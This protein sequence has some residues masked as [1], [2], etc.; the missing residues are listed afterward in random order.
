MAITQQELREVKGLCRYE[1]HPKDELIGMVMELTHSVYSHDKLYG[2]Y[3]TL[4]AYI[5]CPP[6]QAFAYLAK[7]E[8][9]A[10]WTYSLRDF[11]LTETKDLYI[12]K[13]KVGDNTFIYCK[14]VANLAAMTIDY[15]CAWDQ[16]KDLWM[17][18]LMR[19][20]PA[21]LVLNKPGCVILWTNCHHPYYDQNPYPELAPPGRPWVGQFWDMFFAGHSIELTNLTNI[22]EHRY[23]N[24]V[25]MTSFPTTGA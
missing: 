6:E 13:D 19:V 21:Q 8:N 12:G 11:K 17:I 14:T 20:V 1:T 2:E 10:E 22:L 24:Q 5:D 4:Q 15:H 7:T 18:Y 23:K 16:G 9:L 3:C 25:S